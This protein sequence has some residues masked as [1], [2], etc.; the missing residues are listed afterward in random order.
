MRF[1]ATPAE[2]E[3]AGLRP[4]NAVFL[5]R[6]SAEEACVLAAIAAIRDEGSMTPG[7]A[8]MT[9][10]VMRPPTSS[11][12]F[13]R[14]V[15][16]SPAA[17]ARALREERLREGLS[18]GLGV[19]EALETAGYAGPK[20]VY[21]QMK[22]RLGMALNEWSRGGAGRVVHWA[23]LPTSLGPSIGRCDREGRVLSGFG[24]GEAELRARFPRPNWSG[25]ARISAICSPRVL[26]AVEQR[27][28]G[29]AAIR[30]M[31]KATAF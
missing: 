8:R 21:A 2:A 30:S 27:G 29:N 11:E 13:K 12:L 17:F 19:A 10:P 6:Q 5:T 26:A 4:C 28:R 22:G 3:G 18:R 23:V 1:Y 16:L 15:G 20:R 14:T 25:S 24:E 31:S 7:R 9:L